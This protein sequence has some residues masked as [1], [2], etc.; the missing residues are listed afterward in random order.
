MA[1]RIL[2]VDDEKEI[3]EFSKNRLE[4]EGYEIR[5]A[6]D[7]AQTLERAKERPDLILLDI[8]MPGM[9]G[10]EVLRK[11]KKNTDTQHI[12]VIMVT[13]HGDSKL[14]FET[15]TLGAMDYIIKPF[16]LKDLLEL[17]NRY[18]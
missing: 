9:D 10:L 17:I 11:L 15:Q 16:E 4:K 2:V 14:I 12:P 8:A 13:A 18:V 7:G 5:T 3:V 6:Y 1:K